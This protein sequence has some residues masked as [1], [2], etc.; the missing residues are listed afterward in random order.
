MG[1]E[2]IHTYRLFLKDSIRK[3]IDFSQTDQNRGIAPPPIEKP[4]PKD[5]KRI[6]LPQYDQLKKVSGIDLKTAINNRK[7]RRSYSH[8]PLSMEELSFLLW[9]TQGIKQ[10]LDDGHALR[11]VPSAGCRHALETYLCILNVQ[12]LDQGIY[13]YLP[14]EHQ[15]L[16]EFTEENLSKRMS[17]AVFGQSYP[18]VAAVT[19]IWTTIPYRMEWRYGIAAHKVIAIDVG[20]VCQNLYLACEAI[21]AGTCAMAAYDQEVIDELL[22]IDGQDEFTIYLASVGKC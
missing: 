2:L 10:K 8:Q 15:L 1:K 20:H 9:A 4:Y 14:L 16:F 22:R 19:F 3:V 17:Q 7:S 12:D 21:G 6:D 18:E 13:R 5:A 11:T